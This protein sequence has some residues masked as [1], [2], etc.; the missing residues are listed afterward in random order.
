MA[1]LTMRQRK[2]KRCKKCNQELSHSAYIRHLSPTVCAE[3]QS[4][5]VLPVEST[6]LSR[7]DT[8][9]ESGTES[10]DLRDNIANDA[11]TSE[12]VVCHSSDNSPESSSDDEGESPEGES[13]ECISG[14]EEIDVLSES[15][16]NDHTNFS[17]QQ[18]N[19][20][21]ESM[22]PIA[23]Q[24]CMFLSF[25][26]LCNRVSE[27]AISLLLLFLK[28][29]LSWLSSFC[30]EI[31]TLHDVLPHNVYFMRKLLGRKSEIICFVVCQKCHS[32]YKYKDCVITYPS[33]MTESAKCSFVQYPKRRTKCNTV[34][35]K[36]VKHGSTSKL[37]PHAVYAYKSLESS[38]A[39]LFSQPGFIEKCNL[40]RS[41]TTPSS[42]HFTDIY[43]G[44]VWQDFQVVDGRPFLQLPNN[45]CLKLNLDWFNPFKHVQ[46]S[47]GVL[48]FVVEN[49]PRTDRYKLENIIVVG[50]IPGPKE[51]KKHINTYL[52]PI[53]DEL[54]ELWHGKL[55][56]TSSIFGIVP[57]RCAL[58]CITCDLPAT[59]K[60]CGFLSFS[61]SQGCSKCRKHFPCEHFGE[62]LNYSGFDRDEWP[63]RTHDMH[64]QHVSEVQA[65]TTA[66]RQSELEKLYGVRYSELLRLPY[67]DIV[68]HH[69]VDPMHNFLLGTGKHVTTIWKDKGILTSVQF[70]LIQEKVD[71]MRVPSKIGRIPHKISSN[72][73]SF[74]ADQ[75]RN[76]ICVYSLY[77]LHGVLP[78]EHY[79]CWAL[80]VET[81]CY[82]LR[83]SF[84]Y[85]DLDKADKSLIEFCKAFENLYGKEHCTPN[86]H[87]HLHVKQSILNYGP[88]YGFWCFPFERFNGIL[89]SFQKN[90]ISPELQMFRKF[91]T[92]QDLL[93]SDVPS[94]LPPELGEF[95][96]LVSIL[97]L[98]LVK[99][100]LNNLTLILSLFSSTKTMLFV[101]FHALT[102][103][104]THFILCT[105]GM[106]IFLI[107]RRL[108]GLV[109]F[110]IC[111]I[112]KKKFTMCLC[113][114]KGFMK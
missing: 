78:L 16:C 46:Y 98:A 15:D 10:Q 59:R 104:N 69:V 76:W 55:L 66:T 12:S 48:Y 8:T 27:R 113:F 93:V 51:P 80:F 109:M 83:A 39:K 2:R 35:M 102:Q 53:V 95:F 68:E 73:A 88:V 41:R 17:E 36:T 25:F 22:K 110:T 18:S 26:Q 63:Q 13:P 86:M 77:C 37:I 47:V 107:M 11:E 28:A 49:L 31:K 20:H 23:I 4:N 71:R 81:C 30:P 74:T 3:V 96:S 43:D 70:V 33:G 100:Q 38:V 97:R 65:A 34:L 79:S 94:T 90:W 21:Q 89:G 7:E 105:E 75:W 29:L 60:L 85:L 67:L 24:I 9:C 40:W 92:Y 112:P 56:R 45:L 1:S 103:L 32:L 57:V 61:A 58:T 14:S 111:S 5:T 42:V 50:C 72:F 99:D 62:K 52:K 6:P 108:H 84:S 87:M 91:L 82:L 54:L 101:L 64:V 44:K 19:S 114:M 106:K